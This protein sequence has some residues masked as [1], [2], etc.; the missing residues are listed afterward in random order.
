MADPSQLFSSSYFAPI[1]DSLLATLRSLA[2]LCSAWSMLLMSGGNMGVFALR[3]KDACTYSHAHTR[4][5][6]NRFL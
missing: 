6:D 1:P 5:V 2:C 4:L 3:Y